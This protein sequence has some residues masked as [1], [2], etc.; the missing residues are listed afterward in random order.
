MGKLK[1]LLVI[2]AT[3]LQLQKITKL[4]HAETIT[5]IDNYK[6]YKITTLKE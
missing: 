2:I 1:R 3:M 6:N 5:G 4:L